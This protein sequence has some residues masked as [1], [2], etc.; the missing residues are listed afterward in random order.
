MAADLSGENLLYLQKFVDSKECINANLSV[1]TKEQ[2]LKF[3]EILQKTIKTV[4]LRGY[5]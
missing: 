3:K 1:V 4:N 5:S 2:A